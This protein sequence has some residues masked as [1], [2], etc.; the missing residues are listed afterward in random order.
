MDICLEK[1]W[2]KTERYWISNLKFLGVRLINQNEGGYGN[3]RYKFSEESR[4]K[5]SESLK[6]KKQSKETVEKRVSQLRGRKLNPEH[7]AKC[8][9][10]RI[11]RQYKMSDSLKK[12]MSNIHRHKKLTDEQKAIL[13]HHRKLN[14]AKNAKKVAQYSLIGELLGIYSCAGEASLKTNTNISNI[15][16]CC[17]NKRKTSGGFLWK[18][19]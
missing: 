6:G 3:S 4:R 8:V 7:I 2:Q 13:N 16:L 19:V 17:K 12:K 9:A 11:A 1:D 15:R 10:T 18:F 5:I 14:N